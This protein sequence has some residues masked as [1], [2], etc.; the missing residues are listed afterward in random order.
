MARD[1]SATTERA[2]T[3]ERVGR[4]LPA[5]QG[6][7]KSQSL[8]TDQLH[9]AQFRTPSPLPPSMTGRDV[10]SLAA[11]IAYAIVFI[12]HIPLSHAEVA[13][14]FRVAVSAL[15]G[16]LAELRAKLDILP[17]DVRYATRQSRLR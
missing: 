3:G 13:A 8:P 4:A 9:D 7:G 15:R 1:I 14:P 6:R 11:A 17:G 5:S 2:L 10:K 12:D 16:Q